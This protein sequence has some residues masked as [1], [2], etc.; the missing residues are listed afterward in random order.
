MSVVIITVILYYL[1][2]V[3]E[4]IVLAS[5]SQDFFVYKVYKLHAQK[6]TKKNN[7][8][9]TLKALKTNKE[10]MSLISVSCTTSNHSPNSVGR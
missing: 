2:F 6:C 5:P 8:P 7:S 4:Q 3:S 10:G 1:F 9:P